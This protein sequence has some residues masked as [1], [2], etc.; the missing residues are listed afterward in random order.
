MKNRF[1]KYFNLRYKRLTRRAK[2]ITLLLIMIL[3]AAAML[4]VNQEVINH[5]IYTAI[6]TQIQE[7]VYKETKGLYKFSYDSLSVN[8]LQ[9]Q[10]TL[11]NVKLQIDSTQLQKLEDKP[12]NVYE[13][14]SPRLFLDIKSI[15]DVIFEDKLDIKNIK[16]DDPSMTIFNLSDKDSANLSL[17]SGDLYL[18]LNQYLDEFKIE[19][20]FLES[21][22]ITYLRL[23]DEDEQEVSIDDFDL[24]VDNLT[25]DA[26]TK[27][28]GTDRVRLVLKEPNFTLADG[29]HKI[30]MDS[31]LID[32][33][34]E[35]IELSNVYVFPLYEK[36]KES[37]LSEINLYNFTIPNIYLNGINFSKAYNDNVLEINEI[38]IPN[39]EII[40][41][42]HKQ[43]GKKDKSNTNNSLPILLSQLFQRIQTHELIISDAKMDLAIESGNKKLRNVRIENTSLYLSGLDM[44]TI[45]YSRQNN[46]IYYEQLNL[47]LENYQ[48]I[49][50]DSV[51]LL[52][53]ENVVYN[54]DS[55][56]LKITDVQIYPK[57]P[58]QAGDTVNKFEVT[59]PY[60]ELVGF[61]L[62]D[63]LENHE[64]K[65]KSI[66]IRQPE[67][68][69]HN[70]H[71]QDSVFIGSTNIQLPNEKLASKITSEIILLDEVKFSLL[72]NNVP[73]FTFEDGELVFRDYLL[74]NNF[75]ETSR[76]FNSKDVNIFLAQAEVYHH[77]FERIYIEN[78]EG[79]L[80]HNHYRV[81]NL[82]LNTMNDTWLIEGEN[83]VLDNFL[84]KHFI[85]TEQVD[86]DSL[87]IGNIEVVHQ[88]NAGPNRKQV[89]KSSNPLN[90]KYLSIGEGDFIL[91]NHQGLTS[92]IENIEGDIST[93][94]FK[95]NEYQIGNIQLSTGPV[96]HTLYDE[97]LL[98]G[99]SNATITS[100]NILLHLPYA[101][102]VD[103][104]LPNAITLK[105]SQLALVDYDLYLLLNKK[106]LLTDE[107]RFLNTSFQI[108][109][110]SAPE[111]NDRK[112]ILVIHW[113]NVLQDKLEEIKINRVIV[114]GPQLKLEINK[115]SLSTENFQLELNK[116]NT[117]NDG[118]K[119]LLNSDNIRI[120]IK[121]AN[122]DK[123][124][125]KLTAAQFNLDENKKL[126]ALNDL[127]LK[128]EKAKLDIPILF[129]KNLN[130]KKL[131]EEQKLIGQELAIAG[132]NLTYAINKEEEKENNQQIQKDKLP[133]ISFK[134]I[135]AHQGEVSLTISED[136]TYTLSNVRGNLENFDTEENHS[137]TFFSSNVELKASDFSGY[138]NDKN[139]KLSITG[140]EI[141]NTGKNIILDQLR[142]S[143]VHEKIKYAYQIGHEADWID[144]ALNDIT[145][146]G[147]DLSALLK[148]DF[149]K[150]NK[151]TAGSLDAEVYRD[152]KLP[153]PKNNNP[154]LPQTAL[155]NADIEID[156]DTVL[157][158]N[159]KITY[160]ELSE[161]AFEPGE[162]TFS[163]L[164]IKIYN[165]TNMPAEL[166][167][168]NELQV[169]TSGNV[170]GTD[171]TAYATF[172]LTSPTNDFKFAG[173]LGS[174]NLRRFNKIMEKNVFL[175]IEKGYSKGL[176][177]NIKANNEEAI[178]KMK[179][180]YKNLKVSLLDKQTNKTSGLDES[181]ASFF[182]NTFVINSNNPR[183]FSLKEGDIYFKRDKSKSLFNYWAKSFLSGIVSSIGVKNNE[184]QTEEALNTQE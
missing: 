61:N 98:I 54:S 4:V 133:L 60:T 154:P 67:V 150:I 63:Y 142:L 132:F 45:K 126:I 23:S 139:D 28:A 167:K 149:L 111:S 156:I 33:E 31:L 140:I 181:L 69:F 165:I 84:L 88:P 1:R 17:E 14:A 169:K 106:K 113:N 72:R 26:T 105:G 56:N 37:D 145:I 65:L 104:S 146:D 41:D 178:G 176:T 107:L 158:D 58:V 32:S 7:W 59:V 157:I 20:F 5:R 93:I 39:P 73:K 136:E 129:A 141:N 15:W 151:I 143:P 124:N 117:L 102:P 18:K 100:D 128:N 71:I 164:D 99:A 90:I 42:T 121:D 108:Q 79:K 94:V 144:L 177:F 137:S 21:G 103:F 109:N 162:I 76:I 184:K 38:N 175:R 174:G 46:H 44:D 171:I 161:V 127:S 52:K 179:F 166:L 81:D 147:L 51:H 172:D 112:E 30:Q 80:N 152:K 16:V 8:T 50:P 96:E 10:V 53:A 118:H 34:Y 22:D 122:Y 9:E 74:D 138:Y 120:K 180:Y 19:T 160:Q 86:V 114:S 135:N 89:K 87:S 2:L 55:S 57:D 64:I 153:F 148:K 48:L 12:R 91:Q 97:N 159:G 3:I 134:N 25:V 43:K 182:A 95:N 155:R 77:D 83:I 78:F 163:D 92:R 27:T 82:F 183:L 125:F 119:H 75:P 47:Q 70:Q 110:Q 116:F 11:Q 35:K 168:K 6:G 123:D 24:Y 68:I 62:M 66:N 101:K 173:E 130:L 13:I 115:G 29:I 40:I 85:E 36:L 131:A 170:E 49:L